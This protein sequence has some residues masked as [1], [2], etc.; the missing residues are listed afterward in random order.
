MATNKNVFIIDDGT[1]EI[2]LNNTFGQEIARLHIRTGDYAILKRWE[3]IQK[4]F[5]STMTALSESRTDDVDDMLN[6][7]VEAENE[8]I[9]SL[10][11]LFDTEGMDQLFA[12]RS[13]F[14]V[15]SDGSLYAE[16]VFETL[17]SVVSKAIES[18]MK[19]AEKRTN[20]Y[21]KDINDAGPS[22]D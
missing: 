15:L 19:A 5:I 16:K 4:N 6:R 14:S 20:K 7:M 18:S 3:R 11:A 12:N 17:G 1:E 2:V 9:K 22:S 21:L 10:N 13:A 8:L